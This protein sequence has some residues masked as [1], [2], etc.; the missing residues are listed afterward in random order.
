MLSPSTHKHK[1]QEAFK[2]TVVASSGFTYRPER[3]AAATFKAQKWA[4]AADTPGHWAELEFDSRQGGD[5]DAAAAAG[6]GKEGQ[7]AADQARATVLLNYLRSYSGGMG[8]AAVTCV[9]GCTCGRTQLDGTWALQAS[10][11][12]VHTFTVRGGGRS[13]PCGTPGESRPGMQRVRPLPPLVATPSLQVSQHERCR[14][15]VTVTKQP[16]SV[17]QEGHKVALLGLIVSFFPVN[18]DGYRI[19]AAAEMM[20]GRP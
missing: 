18:I 5:S 6:L 15:R 17:P 10:L 9:A 7:G 13:A 3:P 11:Q 8:T 1:Q 14:V 12:Q 16:G 4:W 19:A 20:E 2:G